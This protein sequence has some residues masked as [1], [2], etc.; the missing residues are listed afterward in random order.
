M[1]K[2]SIFQKVSVI[3]QRKRHWLKGDC[4]LHTCNSDGK[5][6]PEELYEMLYELGMDF[7]YIT[8][9]NVNSPG[10]KAFNHK[11]VAIFPGMEISG[12]LGHV[13][14]WGEGLPFERIE[15]PETEEEY[16]ELISK[17]RLAGAHVSVN[18]PF[19]RKLPW[20][21]DRDNYK[22]DSVEVWNSP[23]HTDNVYCLEW[24]ANKI[25][26]GE[27][28]PAV[29]GS[30]YHRDYVVTK[31]LC[32]P[33]TYV[34]A[35]SNSIED[36]TAA[37]KRGNVFV[38]NSPS[39]PKLFL[40]SGEAVPG[41]T[42]E[43]DNRNFVEI[44]LEKLKAGQTLRIYCNEKVIY[45]LTAKT[46]HK[47]I[48]ETISVPEKGFVR[49]DVRFSYSKPAQLVYTKVAGGLLGMHDKGEPVPDMIYSFTNP[50]FFK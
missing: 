21:I 12:G 6:T 50:I 28:I 4:H 38:T 19:D 26:N 37:I 41:D 17:A 8:D 49:A 20:C 43:Y 32:T 35:E 22:M 15:R 33:T 11:G 44:E 30:D 1:C 18:H 25:L 23:M 47:N 46:T 45:E 34:Y 9:H 13:N 42:V 2:T 48:K 39:A 27:F 10:M 31:L 5:F 29:G 36:V 3:M 40:T 16:E 14:I 24:W 7:A